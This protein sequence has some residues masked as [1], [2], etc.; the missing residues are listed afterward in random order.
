MSHLWSWSS[1]HRLLSIDF[2]YIPAPHISC[3]SCFRLFCELKNVTYI[4]RYMV[5]SFRWPLSHLLQLYSICLPRID[6]VSDL[7][8]K[9]RHSRQ[10]WAWSHVPVTSGLR[11]E[12]IAQNWL[13]GNAAR[14]NTHMLANQTPP[15]I[16]CGMPVTGIR[17]V[18][19]HAV[20]Q[21]GEW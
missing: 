19:W 2:H 9:L 21:L 13:S 8:I 18:S 6:L 15:F 1:I 14:N 12:C 16:D 11:V 3:T 5:R 20:I 17:H 7:Q 10:K 4:G